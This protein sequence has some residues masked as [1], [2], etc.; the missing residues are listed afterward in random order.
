M[1][2]S[3]TEENIELIKELVKLKIINV[4]K[5]DDDKKKKKKRKRNRKKARDDK[6]MR[7]DIKRESQP[8]TVHTQPTNVIHTQPR[9]ITDNEKQLKELQNEVF[10]YRRGWIHW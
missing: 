9:F 5:C 10:N 1:A 8:S 6:H 7:N 3:T 2:K 4:D